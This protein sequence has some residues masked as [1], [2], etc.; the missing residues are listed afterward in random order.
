M[1][2]TIANAARFAGELCLLVLAALAITA[3]VVMWGGAV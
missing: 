3:A 2:R 1:K